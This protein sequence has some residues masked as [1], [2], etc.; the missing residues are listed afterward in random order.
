MEIKKAERSKIM[1]E[2]SEA[3]LWL[4]IG[5][6]VLS[7]IFVLWA[8][9]RY[10]KSR[11]IQKIFMYHVDLL[12]L[13]ITMEE[14]KKELKKKGLDLPTT[15]M[16]DATLNKYIELGEEIQNKVLEKEA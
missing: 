2:I 10:I 13:G 11:K 4:M 8:G 3:T 15:E 16:F 12:S 7:A 9:T 1:V 5:C 14:H 6:E